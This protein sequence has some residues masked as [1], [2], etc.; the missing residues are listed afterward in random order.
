MIFYD[1]IQMRATPYRDQFLIEGHQDHHSG[2]TP[3]D[4]QYESDITEEE[5]EVE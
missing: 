2:P 1:Y 3:N 4:T 5:E